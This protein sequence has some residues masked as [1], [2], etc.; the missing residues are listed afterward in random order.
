MKEGWKEGIERERESKVYKIMRMMMLSAGLRLMQ[1][2]SCNREG[3]IER[4][5][6]AHV[7]T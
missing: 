5:N 7:K 1:V 3:E 6:D 4:E 2:A